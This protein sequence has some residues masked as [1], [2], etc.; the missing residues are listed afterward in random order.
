MKHVVMFSGG[1]GSWAAAK[2]VA[3]RH[4]MDDLTLLFA[5]T[6]S[7]DDDTYRWLED[8]AANVGAPLVRIAEGRTIWQVFRD[9]RFLGNSRIDPCS[10]ILKRQFI[11]RWMRE[12]FDPSDTIRYLGY[13]WNERH[14]LERTRTAMPEWRVEAPMTEPPYLLKPEMLAWAEREG[15]QPQRLYQLGFPHANC[16]GGCVKAGIG[17]FVHLL[18]VWPERYAEW[19]RNEAEMQALLGE[20][21][22]I[23][24]DRTG[25]Q[26][27]R[28]TLT[29]LRERLE[30]APRSCDMFADDWGGC[31][32]FAE[33]DA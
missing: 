28:L 17:H 30:A 23:L 12:H 13:D 8:A 32:C 33:T 21:A 16:G 31:G 5:D 27:R 6:K 19:E 20:D 2:R 29:A 4:G 25:G 26:K 11:D 10:K 7:E 3:E 18:R 15:I 9:E 14:R 22:H 24:S 1:I